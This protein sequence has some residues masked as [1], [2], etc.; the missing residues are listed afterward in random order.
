MRKTIGA[1]VIKRFAHPQDL[2]ETRS[3]RHLLESTGAQIRRVFWNERR[4]GS[5]EDLG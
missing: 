1:D 5:T 4:Q 2:A 3:S